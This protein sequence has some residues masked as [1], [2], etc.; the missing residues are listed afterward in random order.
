[1]CKWD[2]NGSSLSIFLIHFVALKR[3]VCS[4]LPCLVKG[5][6]QASMHDGL[7]DPHSSL[8]SSRMDHIP[9]EMSWKL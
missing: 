9:I 8:R 2:M 6:C 7:E 1:M 4:L 5:R 3:A